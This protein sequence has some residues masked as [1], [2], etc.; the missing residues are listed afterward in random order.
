MISID[1]SLVIQIVNF[2]FLIWILNILLYKPIRDVLLQR[3]DKVTGLEQRIETCNNDTKEKDDA[4]A[5]GIKDARAKGLKEKEI[6]LAA[7]TDEERKIIENINKKAQADLAEAREKI[8]QAAGV[9]RASLQ[10]EIDA[11]A[12]AIGQ[13]ILGRPVL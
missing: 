4:F 11:F 9:V 6:L 1:G 13:K 5:S 7:A 2:I 3:N 8:A 10:Q 12:D